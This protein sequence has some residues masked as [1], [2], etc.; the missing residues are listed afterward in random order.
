MRWEGV[1]AVSY[2]LRRKQWITRPIDEVFAFFADAQNLEKITPRWL[3]IKI[4]SMSTDSISEGAVI[5]YRLRLHG[6]PIHWRTEIVEWNP[7][8]CFVDEQTS[9]SYK[10]WRHT[11]RFEAH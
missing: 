4:L 8:H 11:H 10:I 2:T 5:C 3:G 7:P 9:G 1:N 6:I